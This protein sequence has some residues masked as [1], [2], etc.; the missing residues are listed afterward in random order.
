MGPQVSV[1]VSMY[2]GPFW[3]PIFDFEPD[4][5]VTNGHYWAAMPP[6][7]DFE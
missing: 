6:L 5:L 3:V 2:Q 1:L 4:M 7:A